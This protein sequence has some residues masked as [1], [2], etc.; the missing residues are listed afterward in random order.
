MNNKLVIAGFAGVGKT[1]LAKK[2]SNVIDLDAADYKYNRTESTRLSLEELKGTMREANKD[3]PGNYIDIIK[4][5][6]KKYD[7]VLI[8]IHPEI[9]E[10]YD[11]Y[12]ID[13]IL[14]YPTKGNE[15]IYKNRY[16]KRGNSDNFINKVIDSYNYRIEQFE[17]MDKEK[18]ILNNNETLEGWLLKSNYILKTKINTDL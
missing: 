12:N 15:S 8:W 3:W 13:Y 5:S 7:I 1:M 10:I 17:S 18:I 14:C 11:K 4:K 2:Y 16:I 9:L 6:I